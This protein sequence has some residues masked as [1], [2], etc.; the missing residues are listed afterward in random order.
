MANLGQ[1]EIMNYLDE[2]HIAHLVTVRPDGRPHVAPVWFLEEDGRAFV[3]TD[4]N[5]VKVRNIRREPTVALSVATDQRPLKYVV[6]HGEAQ[7]STT[8]MEEMVQRI[9]VRYD[10][11]ERGIDYARELLAEGRMC[12]IEVRVNRVIGWKDDE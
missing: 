1:Q 7:V 2:A 6:L 8:N 5:A 3:M 11:P 9:C 10:G 4:A 12:L